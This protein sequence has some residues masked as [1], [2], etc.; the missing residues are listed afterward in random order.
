M[1][2]A[3]AA[4]AP[5]QQKQSQGSDFQLPQMTD[6]SKRTGLLALKVRGSA[7]LAMLRREERM[8]EGLS[9]CCCC[10]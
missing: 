1:S 10:C 6:R 9:C 7:L 5:S 4:A 8:I 2:S 3:A